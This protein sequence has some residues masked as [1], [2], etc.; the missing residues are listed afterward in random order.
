MKDIFH[1]VL[2]SF[3]EKNDKFLTASK[4]VFTNNNILFNHNAFL[5]NSKKTEENFGKFR[6]ILDEFG[7]AKNKP[8]GDLTLSIN[9]S[10]KLLNMNIAN[11]LQTF[12]A[13]DYMM[14]DALYNRDIL[15]FETLYNKSNKRSMYSHVNSFFKELE[16]PLIRLG[17]D[18][19]LDEYAYFFDVDINYYETSYY[20]HANG[21]LDSTRNYRVDDVLLNRV[22]VE[23]NT[24][25]N[26]LKEK[27]KKNYLVDD[28]LLLDN[29]NYVLSMY[30]N[31]WSL[32]NP[33][34]KNDDAVTKNKLSFNLFEESLLMFEYN[35][36][37]SV[38]LIEFTS[39]IF[40]Y[41]YK[42]ECIIYYSLVYLYEIVLFYSYNAFSIF[43]YKDNKNLFI[44]Y[45]SENFYDET[46]TLWDTYFFYLHENLGFLTNNRYVQN[47]FLKHLI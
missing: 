27:I 17:G 43:N 22:D 14:F 36:Y 18:A 34:V 4:D 32:V 33:T 2:L 15:I 28:Y 19:V 6:S 10:K 5:S 40:F 37:L 38:G 16:I 42:L 20:L 25:K 3:D 8:L 23:P 9:T 30:E 47:R 35:Y 26:I 45:I 11:A 41:E 13:L 12:G 39:C 7:E 21:F 31:V 24:L 29:Y 46:L 1:T 44:D